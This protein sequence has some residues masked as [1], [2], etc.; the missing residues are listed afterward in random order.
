MYKISQSK[1]HRLRT[2]LPPGL[3]VVASKH[4]KLPKPTVTFSKSTFVRIS[5][6]E[7]EK[8][9]K[10]AKDLSCSICNRRGHE[11]CSCWTKFRIPEEATP[12]IRILLKII[13]SYKIKTIPQFHKSGHA[14][15]LHEW[16]KFVEFFERE[17][18]RFVQ[19]VTKKHGF[20]PEDPNIQACP[21]GFGLNKR[22]WIG[23]LLLDTHRTLVKRALVGFPPFWHFDEHKNPRLPKPVLFINL[24]TTQDEQESYEETVN[25][26]K[27]GKYIPVPF[28]PE[29]NSLIRNSSKV[30]RIHELQADGAVKKRGINAGTIANGALQKE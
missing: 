3:K 2:Q 12:K 22:N 25:D 6:E 26:S 23:F 21:F 8:F 7:E 5:Q 19:F 20:N 30:F 18:Q 16:C 11:N 15:R 27:E 1:L 28:N 17:K 10:F 24:V 14:A 29:T 4:K 13:D 9:E